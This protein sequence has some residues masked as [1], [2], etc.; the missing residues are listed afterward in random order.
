LHW[1]S[2]RAGNIQIIQLLIDKGANVNAKNPRGWTPLIAALETQHREA[3]DLLLE[4]G[5]DVGAKNALGLTALY[6]ARKHGYREIEEKL[7]A[8]GAK[9]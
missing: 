5:A 9:E 4:K 8:R 6:W 1:A 7:I 3:A 2:R